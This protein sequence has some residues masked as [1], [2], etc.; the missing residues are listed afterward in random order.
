MS[1][2]VMKEMLPGKLPIRT[3]I[4][5]GLGQASD[6]ITYTL[7]TTYF[8]FFM[9]NVVG[10]KPALAGTISFIVIMYNA[11]FTPFVGFWSD[12][13][14]NKKGRRRPFIYGGIL[15]LSLFLIL[16]FLKVPFE[17]MLQLAYYLVIALFLFSF[18]SICVIPW[19]A[20]GA[21]L[22]QDYNERNLLRMF[23][24]LVA[25]PCMVI[26]SSGPMWVA[27]ALLPKGYTPAQC[28]NI[29]TIGCSIVLTVCALICVKAT[30][31]R[32]SKSTLKE[33]EK[34]KFSF[35]DMVAQF[36]DYFKMRNYSILVFFQVFYV[37][38]YT[39]LSGGTVYVLFNCANLSEADQGLYWTIYGL[40][41]FISVPI[42]T[43][44]ANKFS[45]KACL[46][47]FTLFFII[48]GLTFFVI[49]IN[50]FV[51]AL[52]FGIGVALA[53]TSFWGIFYAILYDLC[54]VYNLRTGKK[55][56][57]GI[58]AVASFIQQLGGALGALCIGWILT[59]IGYSA[60][61]IMTPFTL[62]GILALSTLLP[63]CFMLISLIFLAKYNLSRKRFA[64]VNKA[65]EARDKGEEIDYAGIE[66]LV[67]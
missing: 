43:A 36:A 18:Y 8:M 48:M 46:V 16:M 1:E 58:T 60:D 51:P 67:K 10:M 4:G 19:T 6:T 55:A 65:L 47:F 11:F 35:K 14:S 53:T 59:L 40:V 2:T 3:K 22:T 63:A 57:G 26:A 44:V 42:V 37:L 34:F 33:G 41:S 23:G 21:E 66:D 30:K 31:G 64:T 62:K 38:G 52:I 28:W 61:G 54:E 27:A 29:A 20:F 5:Y 32:D 7:F 24:G 12:N 25:Y 13:T 45:K 9:T 39:L 50:G 17:G 49:G 15:P 56:E